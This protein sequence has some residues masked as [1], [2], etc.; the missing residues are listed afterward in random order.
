MIKKAFKI[1]DNA[2]ENL[3]AVYDRRMQGDKN[4]LWKGWY[5]P[6]IRRPNNGFPTFDD[7]EK[8]QMNLQKIGKLN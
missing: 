8:I 3:K 4:K 2:K 5:D 1:L 6:A 7:L